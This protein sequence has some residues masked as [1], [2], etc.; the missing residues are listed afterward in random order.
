MGNRLGRLRAGRSLPGARRCQ[1]TNDKPDFPTPRQSKS[2]LLEA[3]QAAI[4]DQR[5]RSPRP[6]SAP[7]PPRRTALR[8]TLGILIIVGAVLLGL[9][10]SWI[11]G[12]APRPES[13]A[14][15]AA[16]A[17]LALVEAVSRVNAFRQIRG[18]L[19]RSLAEAGVRDRDM[20]YRQLSGDTFEIELVAGD[21]TVTI[22]S[23]DSLRAVVADA[24][25]TLERR[26]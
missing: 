14:V 1:M 24:I 7:E 26:S 3:A 5:G 20:V 21:S 13:P 8:V 25:R 10:P 12:V 4:A 6:P 22:R 17:T 16:S 11:A 23:T 9:R 19:P 18:T 15:V 2:A